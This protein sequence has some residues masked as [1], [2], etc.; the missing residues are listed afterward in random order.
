MKAGAHKQ[1]GKNNNYKLEKSLG[2]TG[3]EKLELLSQTCF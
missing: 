3:A 1:N 2:K